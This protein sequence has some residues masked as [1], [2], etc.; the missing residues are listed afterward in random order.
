MSSAV[1]R[2]R[3]ARAQRIAENLGRDF[4]LSWTDVL[5]QVG[6]D[7]TV[8]RPHIADAL[9]S[10]G[11]VADRSEAFARLLHKGTKYYVAQQSPSPSEAVAQIRDAGECRS[12]PT[13]W[14][15]PE[16]RL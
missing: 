16:A 5:A 7:A 10:V 14:P 2:G 11:V 3:V 13:P 1:R 4:D 9:V 8:G 15:R 6:P 12:S